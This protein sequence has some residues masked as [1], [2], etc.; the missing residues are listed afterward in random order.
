[1][2]THELI[3]APESELA[4]K[5]KV[6]KI[7]ELERHAKKILVGLGGGSY[8]AIISSVI[9][10]VPSLEGGDEDRF[11]AVQSISGSCSQ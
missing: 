6:M 3:S 9:N 1:M 4:P 10:I 2:K 5:L 7:K 8:E 11:V